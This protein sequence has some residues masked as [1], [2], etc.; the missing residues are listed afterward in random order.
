MDNLRGNISIA[1]HVLDEAREYRAQWIMKVAAGEATIFDVIEA[2]SQPYSEPLVKI[3]L[4]SLLSLDP[5]MRR[6]WQGVLVDVV[7]RTYVSKRQLSIHRLNVG[8]LLN[9]KADARLDCFVEAYLTARRASEPFSD[10]F[11][12]VY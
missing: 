9:P 3:R 6:R 10:R 1:R 8:W 12:W 7:Q 4:E 5:A 11:P 2:A